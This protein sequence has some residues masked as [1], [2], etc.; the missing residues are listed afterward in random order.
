[1]YW[2][3]RKLTPT[4]VCGCDSVDMICKMYKI[5]RQISDI[6]RTL[7]GNKIADYSDEVGASPVG[8]VGASPVG[9]ARLHL[10]SRRNTW[11]QLIAQRQRQS[12]TRNFQVLGFGASHIRYFT[13]CMHTVYLYPAMLRLYHLG[14]AHRCDWSIYM[15]VA[16]IV[17]VP[18]PVH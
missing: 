13:V 10:H 9:A 3:E 16:L 11:R 8:V 12:E 2:N 4:Q 6:K 15:G 14:S 1:M 18:V 7:V 17:P 5:Y